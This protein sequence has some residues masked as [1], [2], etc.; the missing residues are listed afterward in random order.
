MLQFL[1]ACH[2]G[3]VIEETGVEG[4]DELPRF[5]RDLRFSEDILNPLKAMVGGTIVCYLPAILCAL[6]AVLPAKL[7]IPCMDVLATLA[8]FMFGLSL[9]LALSGIPLHHIVFVEDVLRPTMFLLIGTLITFVPAGLLA[10]TGARQS[11]DLA[12]AAI[13]AALGS[14]LLPGVLLTLT[15]SASVVNI[16]PDRLLKTIAECGSRYIIA[17]VLWL[18]SVPLYLAGQAI[19]VIG[20]ATLMGGNSVF[21]AW[22]I[23]PWMKHSILA[24]P[25]LSAGIFIMHYFC[26]EVGTLYRDHHEAF[27]WLFQ[28]HVREEEAPQ[29]KAR[30][31]RATSK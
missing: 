8:W 25:L 3:N 29:P 31:V 18:V 10:I 17:V 13:L 23:A 21:A 24:I 19:L 16:R 28:R 7:L 4:N 5:L 14:I 6:A 26:F 30:L 22:S 15:T 12:S 27:P 20:A 1:V 9:F 11:F 2:Y